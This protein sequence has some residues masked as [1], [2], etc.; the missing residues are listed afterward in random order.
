MLMRPT[1]P[2]LW[3]LTIALAAGLALAGCKKESQQTDFQM[4][5]RVVAKPLLYN[6]V[7]T[8]WR[9]QLGDLFKVRVPD[10]R[11]LVIS[12]SATNNGG[13]AVAVPFL[14]LEGSNRE[15]YHEMQT[16]DGVDNWF[17]L[18]R[19]IAPGET[20]VGNI[21]FDVPLASYRLRLTDGGEPGSERLVWVE[22]PL[23]I[24]TDTGVTAPLPGQ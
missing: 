15:E 5:E 11:F 9:T 4:G 8:M 24:D 19:E 22:I 18:L 10:H 21:V 6:V 16:G 17:G 2:S 3:L 23:R 20:K 13:K 12:L 1:L 7:Q 14:T